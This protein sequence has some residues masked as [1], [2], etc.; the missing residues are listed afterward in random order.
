MS[1]R[2][3]TDDEIISAIV[4]LVAEGRPAESR[5]HREVARASLADIEPAEQAI[6]YPF[7]SLLRRLYLEVANGGFGPSGGIEGVPPDGYARDGV[8]DMLNSR[9]EWRTSLRPGDLQPPPDGVIFL[10]NFGC[11]LWA[12]IDCRTPDGQMWWWYPG[13][14]STTCTF[15]EWLAAWLCGRDLSTHQARD[16][17]RRTD[18][19]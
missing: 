11:A 4:A 19:N 16:D 12:L 5:H 2:L 18:R 7:P 17:R 3:T 15:A 9:D 13:C 10:C 6:G 14:D 8:N 1:D